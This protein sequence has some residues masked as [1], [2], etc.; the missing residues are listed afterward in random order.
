MEFIKDEVGKEVLLKDDS[1]QVMMEWEKPYMQACI[2]ALEPFGDVLEVGFGCGYS[3]EFIQNYKP[4][5]HTIIEYHPVVVKRAEEWAKK[6]KNVKIV[7]D[8]WQE[9]IHKLGVFDTIFFD[10][11]PLQSGADTLYLE[12]VG[13]EASKIVQE[14]KEILHH[15]QEKFSF[16]KNIRYDDEDMEY[17]FQHLIER[18]SIDKAHFLPFFYDLKIKGNITDMQFEKVVARLETEALV[19]AEIRGEFFGTIEKLKPQD[20]YTFNERGDRF[21]EFLELCLKEHMRVGSK[22][23]C[24]LDRPTSKYEDEKFF[25]HIITNP[26]LDFKEHTVHVD[27]PK[28]CKYYPYDEALVIVITKRM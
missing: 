14:G 3:A 20:P 9:A 10:D 7:H 1:F 23:S 12:Q 4:R 13:N 25:N 11:Y 17:F 2:D 6:Y 28:N 24:Y 21:F 16:L 22:F 19:T 8:T 18:E 15:V 26:A 27:V 5:S